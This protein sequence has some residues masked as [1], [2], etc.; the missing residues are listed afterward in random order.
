MDAAA[1]PPFPLWA[2]R[3]SYEK[4][5]RARQIELS[6]R[7]RDRKL[8]EA[9]RLEARDELFRSGLPWLFNRCQEFTHGTTTDDEYQQTLLEALENFAGPHGF[10]ARK[11]AL[12]TFFAR[13]PFFTISRLRSTDKTV[14]RR[15]AKHNI[16]DKNRAAYEAAG[17]AVSFDFQRAER[18]DEHDDC[19]W[20]AY[21]EEET[22]AELDRKEKVFRLHVEIQRL[23]DRMR[24]I[25]YARLAG[26]TLKEVGDEHGIARERV[27]QI[28]LR[29]H[30]LLEL[31][32][33]QPSADGSNSSR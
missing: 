2:N 14:I 25:V 15:P 18:E 6:D 26:K 30:K 32:L 29:A 28:E 31:A 8:P 20:L 11:G 10:D 4:L 3:K 33:L 5:S 23:P 24:Q 1:L 21:N 12:S 17:H 13:R 22:D 19:G 27:R 7:M 16:D 9:E